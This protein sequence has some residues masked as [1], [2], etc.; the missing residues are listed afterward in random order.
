MTKESVVMLEDL[1]LLLLTEVCY[2]EEE[3][4]RDY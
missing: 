1:L 2:D 3:K 4:N